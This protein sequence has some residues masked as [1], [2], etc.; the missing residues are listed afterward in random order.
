[1]EYNTNYI[2]SFK[3][4]F[5]ENPF[6][7]PIVVKKSPRNNKTTRW[8]RHEIINFKPIVRSENAWVMK[9]CTDE[10]EKIIKEVTGI[11]NK[12]SKDNFNSLSE[13][14]YDIEIN[15][16][17][18]VQNVIE[19]IFQ[20]A[21]SEPHFG[22]VYAH[23]CKKLSNK[24]YCDNSINFKR[25]ILTQCQKEFEKEKTE[26]TDEQLIYKLKMKSL[27]NIKFVGE[28]FIKSMVSHAIIFQCIHTLFTDI[29]E[30][31]KSKN[32]NI[33]C[34]CKLITTIGKYLDKEEYK[35]RL[36]KYLNLL[37]KMSD[38]KLNDFRSRFMIKDLLDLKKN[39][40]VSRRS[41]EVV[42][43]TKEIRNDFEK[44]KNFK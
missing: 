33:E 37:E 14:L 44:I 25:E 18:L 6:L 21:V 22:E 36:E 15:N 2:L 17:P 31:K 9:V 38:D 12:L 27:G 7:E 30:N 20:K 16:K 13:K 39:N 41:I 43:T 35:K 4:V 26:I 24:T 3:S 10:N 29:K 32:E 34:I 28:L 23:L 19:V 1:M 40:W 42:K 5:R 11:L 8:A